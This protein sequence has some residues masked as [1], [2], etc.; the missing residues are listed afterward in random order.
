MKRVMDE[1]NG[2]KAL[3]QVAESTLQEKERVVAQAEKRMVVVERAWDSAK[4]KG[5][6]EESNTKLA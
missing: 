3:K 1:A 5:K 6:L 4:H 2:E